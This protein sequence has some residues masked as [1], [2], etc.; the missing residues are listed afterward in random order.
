M[1]EETE[2]APKKDKLFSSDPLPLEVLKS[3]NANLSLT[4]RTIKTA[5]Y[6]LQDTEIKLQLNDGNLTLS[7]LR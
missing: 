7:R 3:A 1:S 4:A 5:S 6:D 2:K